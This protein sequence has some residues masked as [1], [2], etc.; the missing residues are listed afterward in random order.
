MDAPPVAHLV[1][2]VHQDTSL[3]EGLTQILHEHGY[4][5]VATSDPLAALDGATL[6]VPAL[7]LLDVA[8]AGP[9]EPNLSLWFEQRLTRIPTV[10]LG[11][12]STLHLGPAV[13]G[14]IGTPIGP[15]RLLRLVEQFATSEVAA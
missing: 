3:I 11:T 14:C 1:M 7:L 9:T 13:V 5:V 6:S 4:P 8:F 12:R 2:I 10:I 15:T